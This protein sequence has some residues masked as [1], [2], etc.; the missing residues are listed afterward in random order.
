ME[1]FI[2]VQWDLATLTEEIPNGERHFCAVPPPCV[3]LKYTSNMT[4]YPVAFLYV[5]FWRALL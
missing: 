3:A 4:S 1:N 5:Y 2:F